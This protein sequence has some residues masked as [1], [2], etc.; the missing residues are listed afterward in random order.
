MGGV[1]LPQGTWARHATRQRRRALP[2]CPRNA[3]P[4]LGLERA[5]F[6]LPRS[7]E[8]LLGLE[9]HQFGLGVVL[10]LSQ[11]KKEV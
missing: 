3:G 6:D 11:R 1:Q 9:P 4:R 2:G 7:L 10:D 8:A 5:H